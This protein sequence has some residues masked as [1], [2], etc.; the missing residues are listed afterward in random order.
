MSAVRAASPR[1]SD[2]SK[3]MALLIVPAEIFQVKVFIV[4]EHCQ[5]LSRPI[6]T[7]Q[8][9]RL[10]PNCFKYTG[11][12]VLLAA[13]ALRQQKR[14]TVYSHPFSHYNAVTSL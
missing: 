9:P 2:Q 3:I 6:L 11:L 12:I 14:V 8:C 10:V 13:L 5:I 7:W 1:E 4:Q